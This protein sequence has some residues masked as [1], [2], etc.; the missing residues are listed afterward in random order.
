MLII[1]IINNCVYAQSANGGGDTIRISLKSDTISQQLAN[2]AS[3]TLSADSLSTDSIR[4]G[5]KISKNGLEHTVTYDA[6]DSIHFSIKN[7]VAYL[8]NEAY[9]LYEDMSLY[10]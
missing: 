8:F 6:K 2:T 9:V 3:D 5:K 10:A 7:K 1:S 4:S